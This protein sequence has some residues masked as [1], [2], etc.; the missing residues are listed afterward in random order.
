MTYE[1]ALAYMESLRP[2]GI[3]LGNERFQALVDRLG[4]PQE[5]FPSAHVAGTKG[6]GSTTAMIAGILRAHGF[7]VGGYYSPYVYDV[8][9]RVIVDGDMIPKRDFAR[10]V[11][12]VRPHID[13]LAAS[14]LGQTT[15]FE[16]KTAIA[17]LYFAER[18]VDVAAVEVGL[19]G[20]LDATN[21][22][23]P[24]VSVITNIG[25]DH[26][27]I[28]GDTHALIAAEK[29]GIIKPSVP[30]ITATDEPSALEVI[31]RI[32]AERGAPLRL[33]SR[34][35]ARS[36]SPDEITWSAEHDERFT[37]RTASREYAGIHLQL[38]GLHQRANA[39][40]A[41]GAV[42]H[43]AD[44]L[45]WSV[46]P[47]AVREGLADVTL[48]GRFQIVGRRPTVVIDAA[49]NALSARTTAHEVR[50]IAHRRLLLVIGMVCGHPP[51]DV[52]SVLGP[53]ASRV[54]AT[55]PITARRAPA[56]EI[57]DAARRYC[58]DVRIHVPPVQAA[59]A[60]LRD[61]EPDDLVLITGSFCTVGDVPQRTFAPRRSRHASP[62]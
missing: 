26:T 5:R 10:L 13:A 25:L 34:E 61:A 22:L 28:L 36:A 8:R 48:P 15:E 57:A 50:R 43:V 21:V 35:G 31:R 42:E 2:V 51:D 62:R 16:L 45:Q 58:K 54:Y 52:L 17:F 1:Q 38:V 27:H 49:H 12:A 3:K 30:V 39:A 47:N 19:G 23:T 29:A 56:D 44:A 41:I 7:L 33:V 60:A 59:R 37:V 20:R 46:D 32:A 55:Q 4:N 24:L 6:K 9:E 18:A 11:A 14:P 40:C 53:L